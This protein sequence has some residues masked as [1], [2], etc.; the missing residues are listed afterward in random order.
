MNGGRHVRLR[1]AQGRDT[2]R[3]AVWFSAPPEAASLR[4][5]TAIDIVYHLCIDEWNGLQRQELRIRD[6]RPVGE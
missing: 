6:W 4:P 3:D 2:Y 5:G 1:L